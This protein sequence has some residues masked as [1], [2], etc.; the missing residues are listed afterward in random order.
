MREAPF[1]AIPTTVLW[2]GLF[3]TNRP[4]PRP[5]SQLVHL[6]VDDCISG[7]HCRS[8]QGRVHHFVV[9]RFYSIR[10]LRNRNVEGAVGWAWLLQREFG[11]CGAFKGRQVWRCRQFQQMWFDGTRKHA[12]TC[13]SC[14]EI[15]SV[16]FQF[17]VAF[18]QA[19]ACAWA[20]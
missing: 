5:H 11:G 4:A 2:S 15:Q 3:A 18:A 8:L 6:R 1:T 19:V 12:G 13:R 20:R 7:R 16:L 10:R 17:N 9:P 14:G